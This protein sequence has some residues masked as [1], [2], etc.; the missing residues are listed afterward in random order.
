MKHFFYFLFPTLFFFSCSN[1]TEQT[2]DYKAV[3]IVGK[4]IEIELGDS[5]FMTAHHINAIL[6]LYHDTVFEVCFEKK[7][8]EFY[9][10]KCTEQ[11]KK[12]FNQRFKPYEQTN[13]KEQLTDSTETGFIGNCL[14]KSYF[15]TNKSD[16]LNFG[17]V[18]MIYHELI[19]RT[20]I[21]TLKLSEVKFPKI[22]R[23]IYDSFN[24]NIWEYVMS[25][26]YYYKQIRSYYKDRINYVN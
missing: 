8:P 17:V 25:E 26:D 3:C 23:S 9:F 1:K 14:G 22:Y 24:S 15:L 20:K 19:R 11:D 12:E 5:L 7:Q 10:F 18:P 16:Q 4:G 21:K 2:E 13:L 6:F